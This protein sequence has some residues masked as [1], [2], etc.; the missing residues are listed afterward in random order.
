M[1]TG[2]VLKYTINAETI[3]AWR[4]WIDALRYPLRAIYTQR[5]RARVLKAL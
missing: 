1:S 5:A 2:S 4:G 3:I